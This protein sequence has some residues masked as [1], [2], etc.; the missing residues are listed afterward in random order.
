MYLT[1]G[2]LLLSVSPAQSTNP[3]LAKLRSA[4][5]PKQEVGADVFI[6]ENPTYDGRG[7]G[8]AVFDTGVDPAA[9]GMAV[10][11]TGERKVVDIID[12]T[13]SGDV[14]TSTV[15]QVNEAG[16]LIGLSGRELKVPSEVVNPSG[17]YRIG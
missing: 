12:G 5:I 1:L 15:V 2:A 14:D 13:G 7:V 9:A 4:L 8:I 16:I 10:T 11:T 17:D 6:G 3:E